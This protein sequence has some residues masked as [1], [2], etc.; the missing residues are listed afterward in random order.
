M[1]AVVGLAGVIGGPWIYSRYIEGPP[2]PELHLSSERHAATTG[3]DGVWTVAAGRGSE[4]SQVG[5]RAHQQLWWQTVTVD[6]RTDQVRGR[7]VIDANAL[8]SADFVVDIASMTSTHHGRDERFR[9]AD[10]MD[11]AKH[12]IAG[13][14]VSEPIDLSGVP[15]D[16]APASIEVPAQ[17]T[18]KG[19]TRQVAV[20]LDVQRSGNRVLAA[21][22]IG[23]NFA[24]YTVNPPAPFAGLLKVAPDATVEFLVTLVKQ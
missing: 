22:Q 21:G 3:I 14:A 16:G 11:A 7:I 1:L 15:A 13:L 2:D 9:S 4:R 23:V 8:Q 6:G 17:L 5:Y 19:V 20:Q 24:D 18:L 12:P 10:V